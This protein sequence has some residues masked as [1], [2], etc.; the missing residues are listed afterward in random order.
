MSQNKS[1][2]LIFLISKYYTS[3]SV[4]LSVNHSSILPYDQFSWRGESQAPVCQIWI[5]TLFCNWRNI[6]TLVLEYQFI[7]NVFKHF[8][9]ESALQ[10]VQLLVRTWSLLSN[11]PWGPESCQSL[12]LGN[13]SVPN[14]IFWWLQPN[15]H[16]DHSL[17]DP[18]IEGLT[19][20]SQTTHQ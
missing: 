2:F 18:E 11:N 8:T 4:L 15:W 1:L 13:R 7:K 17:K 3:I 20:V 6:R 12:E 19:N 5:I 9:W 10:C 16:L 14:K